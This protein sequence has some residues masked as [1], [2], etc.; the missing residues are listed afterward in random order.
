MGPS[1][2]PVNQA[3]QTGHLSR[4]A[5]PDPDLSSWI[6]IRKIFTGS[7]PGYVKLYKQIPSKCLKKMKLFQTFRQ[8]FP[9]FPEKNQHEN[10]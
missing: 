1:L 7:Y 9:F 6:R 2:A 3:G 5:D 10:I 8:I 4:V